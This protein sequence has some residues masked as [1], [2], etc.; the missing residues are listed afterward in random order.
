MPGQTVSEATPA[1]SRAEETRGA[2][3]HEGAVHLTQEPQ[4]VTAPGHRIKS[5][6]SY[7][8][9]AS[10][11]H[12]PGATPRPPRRSPARARYRGPPPMPRSAGVNREADQS[13]RSARFVKHPRVAGSGSSDP[14]PRPCLGRFCAPPRPGYVCAGHVECQFPYIRPR[15]SDVAAVVLRPAGAGVQQERLPR[16]NRRASADRRHPLAWQPGRGG[17]A[18]ARQARCLKPTP[19]KIPADWIVYY[20]SLRTVESQT[21]FREGNPACS[22][23]SWPPC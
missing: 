9:I 18:P 2:A 5:L 12:C 17:Q 14:G 4:G 22:S 6:G 19:R 13:R 21:R 1:G 11:A 23:P 3:S 8:G 7:L 16:Q 15:C 10:P 20:L